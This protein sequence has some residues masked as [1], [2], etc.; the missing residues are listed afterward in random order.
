[1]KDE[2]ERGDDDPTCASFER[3]KRR[4]RVSALFFSF[5]FSKPRKSTRTQNVE[6]HV[7][8]KKAFLYVRSGN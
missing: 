3:E 6:V 5:S 7:D 8:Q 4:L 1:M 2:D